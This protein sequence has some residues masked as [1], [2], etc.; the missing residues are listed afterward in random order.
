MIA[1]ASKPPLW[2]SVWLFISNFVVTWD[3]LY[4]FFRPRSLIGGDLH[5]IWKPYGLYESVDLAYSTE[6]FLKHDGFPAAQATMNIIEI[7][8]N[9]AYLYLCHVSPSPIS[10]VFG[11]M[12]AAL[13]WGKT[14][15]YWLV[16]YYCGPK[17][18]CNSGQDNTW[19]WI[20]LY[21]FPNGLWLVFPFAILLTLGR[22]LARELTFANSLRVAAKSN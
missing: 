8:I 5:W 10:P 13:T 19:T 22:Q 6:H 1:H 18:W 17:G 16:D 11:F 20:L 7:I 14:V 21:A 9:W 3:A 4:I 2:I 12:G 15:L